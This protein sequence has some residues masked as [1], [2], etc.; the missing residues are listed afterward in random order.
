MTKIGTGDTFLGKI[1]L[2]LYAN[3]NYLNQSR[4]HINIEAA[5]RENRR[6]VRL[7]WPKINFTATEDG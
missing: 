3:R 6:G 7:G 5:S 2:S 4:I 1:P